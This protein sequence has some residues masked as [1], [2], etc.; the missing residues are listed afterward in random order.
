M[1]LPYGHMAQNTG[2]AMIAQR[3]AALHG[4]DAAALARIA[5]QQRFNACHNPAAM[6]HGQ[7]LTV[8]EVLASRM[9]AESLRML[10]IVMPVAG[11]AAVIVT[12]DDVAAG[13]AIARCASSA[14]ANTCTAS[15]RPMPRTCLP[16]RSD[17]RRARPSRWP[18]CARPTCTWR[19]STTAT[20]SPCAADARGRRLLRQGRGHALLFAS[21]ISPLPETS[22]EH[23]RRPAQLGQAGSAGGMSQVIE[24]MQQIQGRGGERQLAATTLPMCR[25][26]AA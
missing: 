20:R 10:E 11:G 26:P 18:A 8:E 25:A 14:A 2:Y 15:R 7:P 24:A 12:R 23:P 9:V 5:V 19:R 22:D 21:T 4:Y 17:R 13:A 6:F 16:R 3:Y 1:D